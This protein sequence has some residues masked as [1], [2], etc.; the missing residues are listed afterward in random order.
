MLEKVRCECL[1]I[2]QR[3][4]KTYPK[5]INIVSWGNPPRIH[6]Q[7]VS[8]T[9]RTYI[10]DVSW[11]PDGIQIAS[12]QKRIM[13]S[14]RNS[15]SIKHI[16]NIYK[17]QIIAE[18]PAQE[19][20]PKSINNIPKTYQKHIMGSSQQIASIPKVSKT[21]PKTYIMGSQYG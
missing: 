4:S 1:C 16:S 8:K 3:V 14:R 9:Y 12:Y 13:E 7:R 19:E 20:C 15:A 11:A 21:Y 17:K 10:E 2:V 18:K 5:R 6:F